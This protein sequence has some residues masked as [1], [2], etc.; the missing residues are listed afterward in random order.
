MKNSLQNHIKKFGDI[1]RISWNTGR[2]INETTLSDI[3]QLKQSNSTT[4][5]E[6]SYV[7]I[8]GTDIPLR[9]QQSQGEFLVL[10]S[11]VDKS[12]KDF[13]EINPKY[14]TYSYGRIKLHRNNVIKIAI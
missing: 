6:G 4:I 13:I 1:G 5:C 14:G 10:D 11:Y 7:K 8:V 9:V 12:Y 2:D 3:E